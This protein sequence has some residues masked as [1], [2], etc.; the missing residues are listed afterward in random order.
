MSGID[1]DLGDVAAVRKGL[2]R[3]GLGVGVEALGDNAALRQVL[4]ALGDLEQRQPAVGADHLEM[5]VA[6]GDVGLGGFEQ[7]GRGLLALL[8]HQLDHA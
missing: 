8:E 7:R 1:L 5:A 4:G 6:V 2:R 3:V